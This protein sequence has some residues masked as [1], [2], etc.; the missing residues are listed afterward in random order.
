LAA[1][2]FRAPRDP[3]RLTY[4][5]VVE[6]DAPETGTLSIAPGK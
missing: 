1:G 3:V 6:T 4:V 2:S 5:A